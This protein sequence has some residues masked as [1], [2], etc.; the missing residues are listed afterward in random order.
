[1]TYPIKRVAVVGATGML[2]LPVT[3]ALVTEGFEVTVLVRKPDEARAKLPSNVRILAAD[4]K[5]A[6]TLVPALKGADAV[7][8]SLSTTPNQ[9]R[10]GF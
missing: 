9:T 10:D 6:E 7:Y 2:G 3:R 4:V 1:M 8:V 5:H